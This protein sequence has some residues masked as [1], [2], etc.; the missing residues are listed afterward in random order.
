MLVI[1]LVNVIHKLGG[2]RCLGVMLT[3]QNFVKADVLVPLDRVT[4]HGLSRPQLSH[5]MPGLPK[6]GL[7]AKVAC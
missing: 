6:I 2:H 4:D 3:R 1:S 7:F 5:L